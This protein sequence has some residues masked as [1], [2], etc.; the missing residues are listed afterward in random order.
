MKMAAK[1]TKANGNKG[2]AYQKRIG[3]VRGS[4]WLNQNDGRT[5]FN[6]TL[7]RRYKDGEEWKEVS[8]FNGAADVVAAQEVLRCCLQFIHEQE[9]AAETLNGDE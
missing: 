1:Q 4:V 5:Y 8:T 6:T 7:V 3:G 2:P 9:D